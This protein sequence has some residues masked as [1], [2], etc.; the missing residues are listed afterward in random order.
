[1]MTTMMRHL[2]PLLS[3]LPAVLSANHYYHVEDVVEYGT[4]V[5]SHVDPELIMELSDLHDIDEL[6][7]VLSDSFRRSERNPNHD[8]VVHKLTKGDEV[9]GRGKNTTTEHKLLL[10]LEQAEYLAEHLSNTATARFFGDV[11]APIYRKVLDKA[12]LEVDDIEFYT[13]TQEDKESGIQDVYNKALY[14]TDF[15]ELLDK[16]GDPINLLSESLYNKQHEIEREY[17]EKNVVVVDDVL[18]PRALDRIRQL[19]LETTVWYETKSPVDTGRYVGAYL[20]DGLHDRILL[21]LAFELHEALPEIMDGH[22]LSF[23]WAYKYESQNQGIR[24]HT[25]FAAV[26]VN[27]WITPDDANLDSTSGGLV[28]YTT[29]PPA[30][31][32]FD[33]NSPKTQE[34]DYLEFLEKTNFA[35]VTVPYKQNRAVIFDSALYHYTDNFNFK[36]GYNNRRINLTI[37]YGEQ[38]ESDEDE[39][40]DEDEGDDG[41]EL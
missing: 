5:P 10:D 23:L 16:N 17:H 35:N 31:V 33:T 27:L 9:Q 3:I 8:S 2:L 39:E 21:A 12:P 32:E 30:D 22:P 18:T 7:R 34:S 15:D 28:V 40:Y 4:F 41:D 29:K 14:V 1:M 19:L 6:H 36:K 37:L 13:F 11:V 38:P 20:N 25:D 24:T 26:N